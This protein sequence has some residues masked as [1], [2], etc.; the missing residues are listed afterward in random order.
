MSSL[1]HVVLIGRLVRDPE[2]RQTAPGTPVANFTLA[3]DRRPK[4]DGGKEADFLKVV[5]WGKLGE[6]CASY[7]TKGRLVAVEGHLQTHTYQGQDG[8]SHTA[9]E[10]VAENVQFLS[11]NPKNAAEGPS[12]DAE[13]P[14]DFDSEKPPA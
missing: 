2:L 10:V 11:P 1:N 5:A 3:V 13:M 4:A 6:H 9:V 8:Q 12:P 7:L 14:D